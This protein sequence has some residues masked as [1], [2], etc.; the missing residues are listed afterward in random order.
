V[1]AAH[2][3]AMKACSSLAQWPIILTFILP[4][5]MQQMLSCVWGCAFLFIDM[6]YANGTTMCQFLQ[7]VIS[8]HRDVSKKAPVLRI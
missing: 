3:G 8:S 7:A 4:T 5:L 1:P 2:T 6:V